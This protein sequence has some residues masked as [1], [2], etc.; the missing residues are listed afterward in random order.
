[1]VKKKTRWLSAIAAVIML[2]SM[3]AGIVVPAGAETGSAV[4]SA[5]QK[6]Y[7]ALQP[8]HFVAEIDGYT[9]EETRDSHIVGRHLTV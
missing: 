1:M 9:V 3:L 2:V 4:L 6:K 7:D 8:E 5:L